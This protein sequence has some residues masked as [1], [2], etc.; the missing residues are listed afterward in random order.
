MSTVF[1]GMFETQIYPTDDGLLAIEQPND[2]VVLLSPDQ[3]FAVVQELHTYY[4]TRHE[5]QE[6]APG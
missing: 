4:D 6:A 2:V 3:L 1:E 5:W